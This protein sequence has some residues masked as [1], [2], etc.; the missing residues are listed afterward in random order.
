M[1]E[2][3]V[4]A[5][6]EERRLWLLDRLNEAATRL[7]VVP[8]DSDVV[9]TYDMRSA[10]VVAH[11]QDRDVWL[12]VVTEDPDY[13]P[14]CRWDGNV[15]ANAIQG[16]PKPEVLR[17]EDWLSTT[18]Y[19]SG[20][21]LRGEVMTLARGETIAAD[22]VLYTDPH[23]SDQWWSDLRDAL[24]ALAA[25]PAPHEDPVDTIGYTIRNTETQFGVT[26]D[27]AV[28]ADVVFVTSHAD[29]HWGNLTGPE[30]TI[31][32][33]ES[34]RRAP[35][36]YDAATLYCHSFAQPQ[37]A[38]RIRETFADALDTKS[39]QVSLLAASVRFLAIVGEGG[40]FDSFVGQLRELGESALKSL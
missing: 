6:V 7:N 21:R 30:L 24:G 37:I 1:T 23:L 15:D 5:A 9:N 26:L 31:M 34:W 33:W 4:E 8:V 14:A 16:V 35:A 39:G 36:G 25:H 28:F 32:D 3:E 20:S 22:G 10:G 13:Q 19:R 12:R 38:D 27:R 17:F 18:D 40:D 2:E 11:D 29:L